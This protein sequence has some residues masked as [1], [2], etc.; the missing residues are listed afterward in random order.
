MSRDRV[1][2]HTIRHDTHHETGPVM[3]REPVFDCTPDCVRGAGGTAGGNGLR[4]GQ[5]CTYTIRLYARQRRHNSAY[6][7]HWTYINTAPPTAPI[8]ITTIFVLCIHV[9][10]PT[11]THTRPPTRSPSLDHRYSSPRTS[12]ALA[13]TTTRRHT[14]LRSH[15]SR[16]NII[17]DVAPVWTCRDAPTE[18]N[19][20]T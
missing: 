7:R 13:H 6:I 1:C 12:S 4:S 11:H 17:I 8:T 15:E 16:A 9:C 2:E 19:E 10:L 3:M 20:H 18:R 14:K 5:F